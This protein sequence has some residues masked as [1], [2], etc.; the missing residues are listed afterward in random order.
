[1]LSGRP[2]QL[3]RWTAGG[4]AVGD[5]PTG[6]FQASGKGDGR[7]DG[8][9]GLCEQRTHFRDVAV[10]YPAQQVGGRQAARIE[11]GLR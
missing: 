10:A 8:W 6:Q 2:E 5:H 11:T 1:M 7:L 9:D 3:V 4:P